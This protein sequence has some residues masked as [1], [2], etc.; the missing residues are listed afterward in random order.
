MQPE[1]TPGLE[2]A[3]RD[4][5]TF[6]VWI[7]RFLPNVLDVWGDLH[8]LHNDLGIAEAIQNS[9]LI[10]V[11]IVLTKRLAWYINL[12]WKPNWKDV[13]LKEAVP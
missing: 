8:N 10:G 12:Y 4:E 9:I 7:Q 6:Y 1:I 11:G 2:N 3:C 13:P 5:D